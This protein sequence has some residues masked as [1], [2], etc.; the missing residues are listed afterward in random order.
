M[1]FRQFR[2]IGGLAASARVLAFCG[3]ASDDGGAST[4]D[5]TPSNTMYFLSNGGQIKRFEPQR[6]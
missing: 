4:G 5:A 3:G 1:R 2:L 6:N